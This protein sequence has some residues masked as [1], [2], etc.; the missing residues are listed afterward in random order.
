MPRRLICECNRDDCETCAARERKRRSRAERRLT[1]EQRAAREAERAA[2]PN[3]FANLPEGLR[4][5]KRTEPPHPDHIRVSAR[6]TLEQ[7]REI[8]AFARANGRTVEQL[9]REA[10]DVMMMQ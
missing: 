4:R 5:R 8:K 1:P 3:P 2:H 7:R 9:I 6:V 10:L